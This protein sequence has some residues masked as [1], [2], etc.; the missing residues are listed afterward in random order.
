MNIFSQQS[1]TLITYTVERWPSV[2]NFIFV[3]LDVY[4]FANIYNVTRS[5]GLGA[6]ANCLQAKLDYTTKT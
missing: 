4:E 6:L 3:H 2:P 1:L 5:V